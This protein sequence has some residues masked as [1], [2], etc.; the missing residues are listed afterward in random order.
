MSTAIEMLGGAVAAAKDLTNEEYHASPGVS[1][2]RLKVFM[3][4]V[5]EY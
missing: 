1:N 2:S 3:D 5:R 4:D